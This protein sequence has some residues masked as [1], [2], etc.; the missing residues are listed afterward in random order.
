MITGCGLSTNTSEASAIAAFIFKLKME[1]V[2]SYETLVT[3]TILNN[4]TL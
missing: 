4:V 3:T 2:F 1:V